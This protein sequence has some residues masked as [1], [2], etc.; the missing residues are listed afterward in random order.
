MAISLC[1][2]N[3]RRIHVNQPYQEFSCD[4]P[5]NH[6]EQ[7]RRRR[8]S[9]PHSQAVKV[10]TTVYLSGQIALDPQTMTMIEGDTEAEIRRVF[11]NLQ[12]VARA[13]GGSLDDMVK[14]NVFLVDL[15]NFCAGEPDHGGV[16]RPALSGEGSPGRGVAAAQCQCRDG[17]CPRTR[18]LIGRYSGRRPGRLVAAGRAGCWL[19]PGM[20]ALSARFAVCTARG[21]RPPAAGPLTSRTLP[22][23]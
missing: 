6:Q 18:T 19:C 17:W 9:G 14:L 15:G 8:R 1:C 3:V 13:A 22:A 16:L 20:W 2:V 11:D 5:G 7:T 4:E 10:G 23:S 12:A 21:G